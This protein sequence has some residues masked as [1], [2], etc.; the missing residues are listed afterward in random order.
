MLLADGT[1]KAHKLVL[2]A[3]SDYFKAALKI[4]F[5]VR[6]TAGARIIRS[7]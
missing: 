4:D 2:C 3:N 7:S 6:Q 1:I 5:L